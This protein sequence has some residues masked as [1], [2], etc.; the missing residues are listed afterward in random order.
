MQYVPHH[1]SNRIRTLL[2]SLLF[3]LSAATLAACNGENH[4]TTDFGPEPWDQ[5]A[6]AGT[7]PGMITSSRRLVDL[8]SQATL[9]INRKLTLRSGEVL[10]SKA[11]HFQDKHEISLEDLSQNKPRCML[12]ATLTTDVQE[13]V[14][15]SAYRDGISFDSESGAFALEV[16]AFP[17]SSSAPT[18][19]SLGDGTSLVEI[20]IDDSRGILRALRCRFDQS[21]SR[22]TL[23]DL[24]QVTGEL[25]TIE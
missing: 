21:G 5:E 22:V 8:D 7:Q 15:Q 14:A 12:I 13:R 2:Y 20:P 9:K 1:R 25:L 4:E 3:A 18:R 16:S 10:E 23:D 6:A 24:A 19:K 17:I 11:V